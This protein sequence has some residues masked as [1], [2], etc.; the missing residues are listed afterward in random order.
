MAMNFFLSLPLLL[1][2]FVELCSGTLVIRHPGCFSTFLCASVSLSF[3]FEFL[4]VFFS[5]LA[6]ILI[7][8]GQISV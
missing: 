1:L 8:L 5:A 3:G 2:L 6:F 7:L 4:L